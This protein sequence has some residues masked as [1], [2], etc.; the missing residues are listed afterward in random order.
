M[1]WKKIKD[2]YPKAFKEGQDWWVA[3]AEKYEPA[4]LFNIGNR[5]LYDFFDEQ[6]IYIEACVPLSGDEGINA[7]GWMI[8]PRGVL[9]DFE[10]KTR[11]EAEEQAFLKA[12]ELLEQRLEKTQ[13]TNT[14]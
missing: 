6:G 7:F 8:Y 13:T 14:L 3:H 10:Y 12:F 5:F 4:F 9:S 1:N 2:K 11:I